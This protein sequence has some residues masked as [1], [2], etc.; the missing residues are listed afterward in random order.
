MPDLK[1]EGI[2]KWLGDKGTSL[3]EQRVEFTVEQSSLS[4]NVPSAFADYFGTASCGRITG[5]ISGEFDL[6]VVRLDDEK[7]IFY[8]QV[9]VSQLEDLNEPFANFVNALLRPDLVE[10]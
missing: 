8:R 6:E 3:R 2:V 9:T 7:T 10:T 5:W 4:S 1:I